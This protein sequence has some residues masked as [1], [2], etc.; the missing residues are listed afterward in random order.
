MLY[1]VT[2]EIPKNTPLENPAET[3]LKVYEP[4]IRRI[5]IRIPPGHC[6]RAGLRIY[7]GHDV[8]FPHV[9]YEWIKG[10]DQFL[11]PEFIW[12]CPE[13]PCP[14]ILKGYNQDPDYDHSFIVYIEATEEEYVQWYKSIRMIAQGIAGLISLMFPARRI[15]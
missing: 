10:D 7:Y 11:D 9:E 13:S 1:V 8:I 14:L 5:M 3:K 4:W 6:A 12:K 2:L 15:R